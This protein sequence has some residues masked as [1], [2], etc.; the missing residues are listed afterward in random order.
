MADSSNNGLGDLLALFGNN[1]PFAGI[2]KSIS[3]FQRGVNQFLETVEKFNDTM[4]Q[5]NGVAMRVN[6]LLDTV[7]EP[8][9]AFVPQ[10][11]RTIR[12]A[13]AMV[14]QLSG[15]IEKV[16]PSLTRFADTLS[17]PTLLALPNDLAA[18]METLSD[19]A[20]RL[21][22][23]GQLA[24]SAGSMFGLRPL[25]VLRGGGT[26]PSPPPPP[27]PAPAPAPVK[28]APAKKAAPK[29]AAA[30]KAPA[31]K[32]PAKKSAAKKSR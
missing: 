16:A 31:K 4:E 1:N 23:L 25:A 29:K 32:T 14:E 12:A 15:P 2:S 30:K 11:T 21:Q 9:K 20:H 26:R 3:Q 24:E 6:S 13:D 10:V 19:L 8:I 28:K 17:N 27:A 7:E 18:F 5:L 22:P